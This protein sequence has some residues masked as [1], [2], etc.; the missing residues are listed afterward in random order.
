ML[1]PLSSRNALVVS[2][3]AVRSLRNAF[4]FSSFE[5]SVLPVFTVLRRVS[6]I[7]GITSA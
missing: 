3:N 6:A 7:A 4:S 2:E 1:S 5:T